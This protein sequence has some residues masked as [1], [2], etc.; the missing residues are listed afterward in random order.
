MSYKAVIREETSAYNIA[1]DV[2]GLIPGLGEFADVTNA[3]DYARKGDY[4]FSAL[5]LVSIIP[6][7]G[8][9]VG[10]SGKVAIALSKLGKGGKVM[11]K[12]GQAAVKNKKFTDV[13]SY[14]VKLKKL[15]T[16][17]RD[18]IDDVFEKA[19]EIDNK[20]LQTHLPRIREAVDLFIKE[21]EEIEVVV[22]EAALRA[23]VR[24]ILNEGTEF[25]ELDSPLQ[26]NKSRNVK[27]IAYCDN[28]V[29]A[30]PTSHDPY[31]K[32]WEKWRSRSKTGRRLKKRVLDEI[33]P[34]VSDV[35][36]IGFLDYHSQGE[37]NDGA[38][39]MWYIDY[40][41]TRS[42]SQGAGVASKLIDEFYRAVAQPGDHVSFGKMMRRSIGHLKDKMA[43]KHP[44][45]ATI[46]AINY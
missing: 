1:L 40:M 16:A 38:N 13:S 24:E 19:A 5:S 14:I 21:A 7:L 35:C 25:R 39:V 45:I 2:A 26:Y 11:S 23:C 9:L 42:D 29:T 3:L 31:F 12:A 34:G 6:S 33:I 28:G 10:K 41:K 32:E 27:R 20:E 22:N 30:P 18:L 37:T 36:I 15:L 43:E 17:N 8:D 44:E 46:G 4:L